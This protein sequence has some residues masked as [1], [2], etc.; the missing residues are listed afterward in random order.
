MLR[1]LKPKMTKTA[2]SKNE[3]LEVGALLDL[4]MKYIINTSTLEELIESRRTPATS[5]TA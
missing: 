2:N 1:I 4:S 3:H 5:C